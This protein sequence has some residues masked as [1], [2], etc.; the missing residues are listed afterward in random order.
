MVGSLTVATSAMSKPVSGERPIPLC[1]LSEEVRTVL[2]AE[3][4]LT[5]AVAN[6]ASTG[7]TSTWAASPNSAPRLHLF[8]EF[9]GVFDI[10]LGHLGQPLGPE[11]IVVGFCDVESNGLR[12]PTQL[13]GVLFDT[14][15][16]TGDIRLAQAAIEEALINAESGAESASVQNA[17]RTPLESV[18]LDRQLGKVAA[19]RL[20]GPGSW[21]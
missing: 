8:L 1:K 19:G 13:G 6:W 3:S 21:R 18:V 5:W 7:K 10:G 9:L 15:T 14:I 11:H 20:D 2:F 4:R 16:R 17:L 12:G